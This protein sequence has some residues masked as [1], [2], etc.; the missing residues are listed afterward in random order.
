MHRRQ[1]Q[2]GRPLLP[3]RVAIQTAEVIAA[4][5]RRRDLIHRIAPRRVAQQP[6]RIRKPNVEQRAAEVEL[7]ANRAHVASLPDIR[8][9]LRRIQDAQPV[10]VG[11]GQIV[12][13]AAVRILDGVRFTWKRVR[14][15]A[16]SP[17][18][19]FSPVRQPVHAVHVV[20]RVEAVVEPRAPLDDRAGNLQ[21]R[22]PLI[23]VQTA[24]GAHA[25]NEVGAAEAPAVVSHLGLEIQHAGRTPAVV[26]RVA[27]ALH[28]HRLNRLDVDPRFQPPGHRIGD[29]E[30]V[31]RVVGLVGL[32]AVEVD[33]AGVVLHHAIQQRQRVAKVLR[34]RIRHALDLRVVEFLAFRGLLR[35]DRRWRIGHVDPV[36]ELLQVIQRDGDLLGTR[37]D[38]MP[39]VRKEEEARPLRAERVLPRRRKNRPE[40][41][42]RV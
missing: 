16:V 31:Q 12:Q 42:C 25:G 17:L 19:R 2:V 29:V 10:P 41:P 30:A 4:I 32:A 38:R 23:D 36:G 37:L 11:V 20:E 34:R 7:I 15:L 14:S 21:P 8:R 33:P 9:G 5:A 35:I 22:R 28:V 27:A 24:L 40:T 26:R 1:K 6:A 18:V 13:E 3:V 39:P